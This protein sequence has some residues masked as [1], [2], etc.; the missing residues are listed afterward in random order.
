MKSLEI[1]SM[2]IKYHLYN[3]IYDKFYAVT[4]EV[5]YDLTISYI[6]IIQ[7]FVFSRDL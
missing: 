2:V 4:L 6:L 1:S 7:F 5:I 3:F